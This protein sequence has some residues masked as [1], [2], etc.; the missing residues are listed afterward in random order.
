V[1]IGYLIQHFPPEVGAGAARASEL[2]LRWAELGHEVTII[3]AMPN[4]PMRRIHPAY[5]ERL[6]LSETWRGIQVHRAWLYATPDGG[7]VPT[8]ANNVSFMLTGLLQTLLRTG[9]LDVLIASSPPFFQHVSGA[10]AA[11]AKGVPLVL[12]VRDLWPDYLV[13]MGML[14]SGARHTRALFSL[15]RALLR[16]ADGV[17]VVTDSFRNRLAAKGVDPERVAVVPNGVD[18]RLYKAG[19]AETPPPLFPRRESDEIV[20]G[21]L[22]NFGAGQDLPAVIRAFALAV[23]RGLNGRLV[24]MGDGPDRSA[25]QSALV[26]SE[27]NDRAVIGPAI[28]REETPGFYGACDACIVPLAAVP[29]FQETVPSKLFEVMAAERPVIGCFE[30]EAARIVVASGSGIV[31]SPADEASIAA[32]MLHMA[33]LPAPARAAMG[34]SGRGYVTEHHDRRRLA[35]RYAAFLG[36]VAARGRTQVPDQMDGPVPGAPRSFELP[37]RLL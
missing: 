4:R 27:L 8:I 3:T 26:A 32:A 10:A 9:K 36:Q 14:R 30:G 17:V 16:S 20:I 21:Y 19:A 23:R 29:V 24:L 25:L 33:G 13:D 15:E 6:F 11:K 7:F 12:E 5:R 34:A 2:S 31:A 18:L 28:P 22:G 37:R 1:R 35:D